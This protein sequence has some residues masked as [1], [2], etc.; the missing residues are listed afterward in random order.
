MAEML[1]I[2]ENEKEIGQSLAPVMH[3]SGC[4]KQRQHS[5][6]IVTGSLHHS[7]VIFASKESVSGG[8]FTYF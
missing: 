7:P 6:N 5:D 4:E 1:N 8:P 3:F 2:H